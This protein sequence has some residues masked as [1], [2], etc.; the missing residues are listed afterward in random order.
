MV[1][2][3]QPREP[4]EGVEWG[5]DIILWV[6][7][8]PREVWPGDG[9]TATYL[10]LGTP[11]LPSGLPAVLTS[12]FP[13]RF[14]RAKACRRGKMT[15]VLRAEMGDFPAVDMST[16]S[17][18]EGSYLSVYSSG[19]AGLCPACCA[20]RR[21]LYLNEGVIGCL[22]E[23]VRMVNRG[24]RLRIFGDIGCRSGEAVLA[25]AGW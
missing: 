14:L 8:W 7:S 3:A 22:G 17:E 24:C 25:P 21:L 18:R 13:P 23:L 5:W 9:Q 6:L 12:L 15:L 1:V 11:P 4:G 19:P 2:G 16:A 20:G 10:A